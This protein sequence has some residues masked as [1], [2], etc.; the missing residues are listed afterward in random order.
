MLIRQL[1][2]KSPD[3][4]TQ[5][6]VFAQN[7]DGALFDGP[8]SQPIALF[9][10][11]GAFWTHPGLPR[12]INWLSTSLTS[13]TQQYMC[14]HATP[15]FSMWP[16]WPNTGSRYASY[17]HWIRAHIP[18]FSARTIGRPSHMREHLLVEKSP[19][20]TDICKLHEIPTTFSFLSKPGLGTQ[21][22]FTNGSC[23]QQGRKGC[24]LA[25]WSICNASTA[26]LL[27]VHH[28]QSD[29]QSFR[30]SLQ[31]AITYSCDAHIWS[32]SF[33][34]V[35]KA[36]PIISRHTSVH[37]GTTANHDLWEQ[38]YDLATQIHTDIQ[39]HRTPSHMD[40]A[41]CET[42]AEEW[43]CVWNSIADTNA[44]L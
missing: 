36:Q 30:L 1:C 6:R 4:L 15:G 14:W 12:K 9:S 37:V 18:D 29:A 41:L 38:L 8:F 16:V 40:L 5:W 11:T 23:T 20:I 10:K 21:H 43:C 22:L 25:S 44:V 33:G 19:Y 35:R 3:I 39:I 2:R 17:T 27:E 42:P 28:R 31:W 24:T 34:A 13:T 7:Y 26:R 32:D